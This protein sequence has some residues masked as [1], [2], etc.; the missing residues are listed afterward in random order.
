MKTRIVSLATCS[1]CGSDVTE[2]W[3][4]TD[5]CTD[6]NPVK[7]MH[8]YTDGYSSHDYIVDMKTGNIIQRVSLYNGNKFSGQWKFMGLSHTRRNEIIRF[9]TIQENP[10]I[11]KSLSLR[12]KSGKGQYH[13]RD[14]DHGT[15]REWGERVLGIYFSDKAL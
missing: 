3:E 11:I 13:V 14:L 1:K 2:L 6:C 15:T 7:Y 4:G 9:S 8:I 5:I 10:E 12:F